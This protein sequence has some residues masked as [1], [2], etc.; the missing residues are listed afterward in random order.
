MG[1]LPVR[2]P[3]ITTV[4]TDL[5]NTLWDWFE[6]WYQSFRALLTELATKLSISE[7]AL[8]PQ[9]KTVFERHGTTEYAFLLE[10]LPIIKDRFPYADIRQEFQLAIEAHRAARKQVTC[11]YPT[12]IETLTEFRERGIRVAAY[13]ESLSYYTVR[14]IRNLKLDGLLEFIYSP[15]DHDIPAGLSQSSIRAMPNEY[16]QLKLSKHHE[17]PR[18][19]TKPDAGILSAILGDLNAKPENTL[20]VGDSLTKDIAMAQAVGTLDAH[21]K[22]GVSHND[23]RYNLLRAV[24]HWP[25]EMVEREK[26]VTS[27]TIVPT[28]TL[29]TSF[30][31]ILDHI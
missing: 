23:S 8:L 26:A 21:A 5:D 17:T 19:K 16:Y 22:Y 13:T 30:S 3:P 29:H 6:I 18:G 31:E 1:H 12:V 7:D 2:Q 25:K 28:I 15:P 9:I 27:T 4:V 11:L 14:R 20:Y 10:E 24:T